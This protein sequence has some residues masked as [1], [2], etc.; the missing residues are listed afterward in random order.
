[1][2]ESV[3]HLFPVSTI[4]ELGHVT[5]LDKSASRPH[6]LCE[7][8]T[9]SSLPVLSVL[10]PFHRHCVTNDDAQRITET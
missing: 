8:P 4:P 3:D 1:M 5:T 9:G 6:T 2:I 7:L 10:R